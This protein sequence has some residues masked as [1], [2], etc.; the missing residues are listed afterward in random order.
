MFTTFSP[1]IC[2]CRPLPDVMFRGQRSKSV[3]IWHHFCTTLIPRLLSCHS[4]CKKFV[5]TQII[6]FNHPKSQTSIIYTHLLN[7]SKVPPWVS[8]IFHHVWYPTKYVCAPKSS[9]IQGNIWTIEGTFGACVYDMATHKSK[10]YEMALSV[11][12]CAGAF[13]RTIAPGH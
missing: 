12:T 8:Y 9:E 10:I 4:P 7:P 6:P 5:S 3:T 1:T 13:G 11:F 2:L